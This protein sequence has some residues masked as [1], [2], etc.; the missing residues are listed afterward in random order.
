MENEVC[1]WHK[2]IVFPLPSFCFNFDRYV[3][4]LVSINQHIKDGRVERDKRQ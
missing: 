2:P 3:S 4:Y 1:Q